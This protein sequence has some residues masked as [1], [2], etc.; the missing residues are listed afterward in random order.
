MGNRNGDAVIS[1]TEV[2]SPGN[3]YKHA[4]ISTKVERGKSMK[5]EE[6]AVFRKDY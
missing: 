1:D 2:G 4:E 3:K 6:L 5:R